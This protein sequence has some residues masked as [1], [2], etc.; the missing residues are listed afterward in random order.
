MN[1]FNKNNWNQVAKSFHVTS[2]NSKAHKDK[3]REIALT[4]VGLNPEN[5]L[6]LGCGTG[7]LEKELLEVGY[8]GHILGI[9]GSSEMLALAKTFAGESEKL[10]Y[11]QA[12]LDQEFSTKERFDL[13]VSI[14]LFFF[15][16]EKQNFLTNVGK[17]LRDKSSRFIMVTPHSQDKVKISDYIGEHFSNTTPREK[18]LIMLSELGN[19][20]HYFRMVMNELGVRRLESSGVLRAD[21]IPEL[22]GIAANSGLKV[23]NAVETNDKKGII[24]EMRRV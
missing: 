19:I 24:V 13:I 22:E 6:D 10:S 11:W 1:R 9:D 23:I 7:I 20:P 8:K 16:L 17:S 5:V 14:N 12:N 4:I 3:Y 21:T 2:L 18:V 15:L